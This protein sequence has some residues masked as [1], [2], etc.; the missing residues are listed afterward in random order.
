MSRSLQWQAQQCEGENRAILYDVPALLHELMRSSVLES[1]EYQ[2]THDEYMYACQQHKDRMSQLHY[3]MV[4]LDAVGAFQSYRKDARPD[5]Y[6][7]NSVPISSA[8]KLRL[9][10]HA[11]L[12]SLA[13]ARQVREN[14]FRTVQAHVHTLED[15]RNRYDLALD[16]VRTRVLSHVPPHRM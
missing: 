14:K 11:S 13:V 4:A 8:M 10:H 7:T 3:R 2:N 9:H 1:N 16:Q 12:I 6:E 5:L 15:L